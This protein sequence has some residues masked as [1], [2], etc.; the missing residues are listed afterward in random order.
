MSESAAM[1][2]RTSSSIL[3]VP[4]GPSAEHRERLVEIQ[5]RVERLEVQIELHHRDG[6][7]GLD[8]DD[9]GLGST[10][11]SGDRDR[12]QRACDER[13]DDVQR[14][15]VDDQPP[16]ALPADALGE[17]VPQ[18]EDLAVAQVGLDRGD[19]IL[20]LTKDRDRCFCVQ[21]SASLDA[22][23][24]SLARYPIMR[25]AS[26]RPPWRSPT[27]FIMLR[28]T[29][30]STSVC[31]ILDERPV[32]IAL[33][34]ISRAASTVWTRWFATFRSIVATP[35]MSI[36]TTRARL[37]WIAPSSCS[38]SWRA[39]G[40]SRTPIIG[41]MSRRSRT[42]R[43]GV[44]SSRIASCCSRITRSRSWTKLTPTV[45]AIRFAAGS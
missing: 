35:V 16:R 34:P 6:D 10:K 11:P 31:A 26:S 20:A 43:T 40:E 23:R 37:D 36:T 5:C 38:V 21:A 39:R 19:Q 18:R 44:D 24:A 2:I 28:S 17:V 45:T 32:M 9:D 15:D 8:P 12:A 29:P 33:A 4:P 3:G 27:V 22:P 13:I 25:S 7:V 41:R 1:G 14:A 30:R 42:W